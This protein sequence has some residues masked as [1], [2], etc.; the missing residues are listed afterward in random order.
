MTKH[1]ASATKKE[2]EYQQTL[3]RKQHEIEY[4]EE[5]IALLSYKNKELEE[6]LGETGFYDKNKLVNEKEEKYLKTINGYLF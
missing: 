1:K 6:Q 5:R 4:C 3:E 2:K